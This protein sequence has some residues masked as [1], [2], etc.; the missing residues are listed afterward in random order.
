LQAWG[1]IILAI[2]LSLAI[3]PQTSFGQIPTPDKLNLDDGP[4]PQCLDFNQDNVC[5]S[6]LLANGTM[7]KNPNNPIE[8]QNV[9]IN[10]TDPNTGLQYEIPS[11]GLYCLDFDGDSVCDIDFENGIQ[12]IYDNQNQDP[13]L[14]VK[15]PD[16][17]DDKDNDRSDPDCWY[18]NLYVCDEDGKCDSEKFDCLTDCADGS[19]VTTGEDLS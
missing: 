7:I 4:T 18:G 1:A 16:E 3:L 12:I 9:A 6:L 15:E 14:T 2:V 8:A 5:E 17:D 19:T 10:W 13:T 11:Q